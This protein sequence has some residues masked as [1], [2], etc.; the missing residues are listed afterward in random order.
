MG[1]ADCD[2]TIDAVD[3]T[4]VL[5]RTAALIPTLPCAS[6]ADADGNGAI[7]SRDAVLILQLVA[8]LLS[9]LPP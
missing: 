6:L 1:D 2:G 7:D 3:A 5:Q 8:G 9:T 4:L